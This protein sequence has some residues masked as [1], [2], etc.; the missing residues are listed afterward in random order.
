MVYGVGIDAEGAFGDG[1]GGFDGGE[2]TLELVR[3]DEDA[4]GPILPFPFGKTLARFRH[5][6]S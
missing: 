4:H 5:T 6:G 1:G 2:G 3:G